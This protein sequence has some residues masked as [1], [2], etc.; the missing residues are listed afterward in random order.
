MP[1]DRIVLLDWNGLGMTMNEVAILTSSPLIGLGIAW[2]SDPASSMSLDEDLAVGCGGCS[3]MEPALVVG[4][5]SRNPMGDGV[6]GSW[7][8]AMIF[9]SL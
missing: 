1:G 8:T 7:S 3:A 2:V 6:P 9:I 4:M 5:I